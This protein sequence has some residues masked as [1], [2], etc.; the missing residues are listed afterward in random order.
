[1]SKYSTY[2]TEIEI[3]SFA[4]IYNVDMKIYFNNINVVHSFSNNSCNFKLSLLFFGNYDSGYYDIINYHNDNIR[5]ENI[6]IKYNKYSLKRKLMNAEFIESD[7]II[8]LKKD[9]LVKTVGEQ[10]S[11]MTK[12]LQDTSLFK[13]IILLKKY[14][15]L[16]NS[17]KQTA[18]KKKLRY[19]SLFE[20]MNT[21]C[22]YCGAM[23]WKEEKKN[24]TVVKKEKLFYRL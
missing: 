21:K 16:K 10:K 11:D 12:I 6:K 1:M 5:S 8:P 20:G 18:N 22:K 17:N 15:L 14:Q 9:K 23:F 19:T 4:E 2:G 3:Q 24:L 7:N 13:E